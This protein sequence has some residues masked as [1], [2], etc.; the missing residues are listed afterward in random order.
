MGVNYL[1]YTEYVTFI[2]PPAG[3]LLAAAVA[4][5]LWTFT[6]GIA[7]LSPSCFVGD[8]IPHLNW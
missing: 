6:S 5:D 2:A 4:M 3:R 1:H 8:H 7:A